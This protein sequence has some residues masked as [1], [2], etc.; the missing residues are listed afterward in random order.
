MKFAIH[1]NR[2]D[3]MNAIDATSTS[4]QNAFNAFLRNSVQ[5]RLRLN[6]EISTIK[7]LYKM[8]KQKTSEM[9]SWSTLK[10][11]FNLI[12]KATRHLCDEITK[13]S[14]Y[15]SKK[16]ITKLKKITKKLKKIIDKT[17][18]TSENNIWAK[19]TA[20]NFKITHSTF[21]ARV[22]NALLKR[23]SNR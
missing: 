12:K 17:N 2:R 15:N 20:N 22:I 11:L 8:R 13:K 9:I 19:V 14:N 21:F 23:K 6:T 7:E 16:H 4:S 1:L 5:M 18:N 3:M 10:N